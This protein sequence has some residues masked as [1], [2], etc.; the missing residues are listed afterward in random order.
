MSQNQRS[1]QSISIST[2]RVCP[3]GTVTRRKPLRR[4]IGRSSEAGLSGVLTYTCTTSSALNPPVLRTSTLTVTLS[5]GVMALRLMRKLL[6]SK[7]V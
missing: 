4:L 5:L 6:Y 2:V 1:A 3:R 7:V